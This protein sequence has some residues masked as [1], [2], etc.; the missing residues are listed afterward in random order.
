MQQMLMAINYLHHNEIAFRDVTPE[1]WLFLDQTPMETAP[2]KLVD[3]GEAKKKAG[4]MSMRAGKAMFT[5]PE[6]LTGKYTLQVAGCGFE[7]IRNL[8]D[9]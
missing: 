2:L 8:S 7:D 5:A 6:V 4:K 3:F 9:L 1:N